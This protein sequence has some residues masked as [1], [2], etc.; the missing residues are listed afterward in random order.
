[1]SDFTL[2]KEAFAG[3]VA[4]GIVEADYHGDLVHVIGINV[5]GEAYIAF[6]NYTLPLDEL[7]P[8][9]R[10]MTDITS[11]ENRKSMVMHGGEEYAYF[12]KQHLDY[13]GLIRKGLAIAVT[14]EYNPYRELKK[15]NNG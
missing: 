14:K 15:K 9:L 12:D 5:Y 6:V 1:M 10:P 7:K 4:H 3:G 11:T 2:L 8:Y 13:R